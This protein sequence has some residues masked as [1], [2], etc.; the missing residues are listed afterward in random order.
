MTARLRTGIALLAV[1]SVVACKGHEFEPPDRREQI[2]EAAAA[3]QLADFDTLTWESDSVRV[4]E[5][6]VVFASK[7]R[8]C[9]GSLGQGDTEYARQRELE[10]PSLVEA[11]WRYAN[12]PDSVRR[13]I[14][15]G[16]VDGMPTWGIA[17]LSIREIDA[18]THYVLDELR[19]D[20][21]SGDGSGRP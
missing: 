17:G 10:P 20:V 8:N 14:F 7:C 21:L 12:Q 5:G 19:P 2:G 18:V 15:I 11:G 1:T 16:H 13:R 4:F 3:Y 6:N 9:H